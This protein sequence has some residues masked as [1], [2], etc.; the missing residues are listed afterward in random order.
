[1]PRTE[2]ANQR[3]REE[4]RAKI[5]DAAWRAF[6][7][8][9]TAATMAEV[10]AEAD[11]SYGLVYRYFSSKEAIFKALVEQMLQSGVLRVQR[12]LDQPGTPGER[13]TSLI[14]KIL[15]ARR[16]RSEIFLLFQHVM[17]DETMSEDVRKRLQERGQ[18]YYDGMRQLIVEAQATGEVVADDPD[19]LVVALMAYL[20][21][22]SRLAARESEMLKE[23][24]PDP[25]IVLRMLKP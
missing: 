10:A 6:A 19:Q 14:T 25:E 22:L 3:I 11:V 21:G 9:G 15:E 8:K 24:F 5:L 4:Q 7:K 20:D 12:L 18:A 23:H 13:L 1:M 17:S 16:E 2:E